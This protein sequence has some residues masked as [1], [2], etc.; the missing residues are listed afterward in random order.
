MQRVMSTPLVAGDT[1]M[2]LMIYIFLGKIRVLGFSA[3]VALRALGDYCG[4]NLQN[5]KLL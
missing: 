3:S 2:L 1:H 4:G 5:S